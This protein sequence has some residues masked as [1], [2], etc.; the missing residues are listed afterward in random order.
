MKLKKMIKRFI[1]VLLAMIMGLML[2]ACGGKEAEQTGAPASEEED[3]AA[4]EEETK[5]EEAKEEE[6]KEES[7]N[8]ISDAPSCIGYWKYDGQEVYMVVTNDLNWITY[9]KDGNQSL[10]GEVE[11]D[12]DSFILKGDDISINLR[13]TDEGKLVDEDGTSFTRMDGFEFATSGDDELTQTANF[14]WKFEAYS[15]NY[16]DRMN[17]KPRT[18]IANSLDFGYKST[19]K[20]SDDYFSTIMVTFQPLVD[21][22]KYMGKGAGLAKPCMGYLLN[23]AMDALYGKYIKKSLGTDFRDRGS[24]YEIT[25]YMWLDGNI[26]PEAPDKEMMGVMQMRYFGPT[27]YAL[28]AVTVAPTETIENYFKVCLRMLN[29]CTYKT[30]WSTTPKPVPKKAGK[31]KS[32][33]V[34]PSG[35]SGDYGTPYYWTDSDGD[36]WYWNGRENIFQSYGDDGYIDDDGQFYESNDAGWDVD[37][38]VEDYSDWSDPGDY[39]DWSDPGDYA[40]YSDPGD[41]GDYGDYGDDW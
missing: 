41:Y 34:K 7:S 5:E 33:K 38:Y 26:Y 37:N 18:D 13:M 28:I 19:M 30:N 10:R 40:D 22:D 31:A 29:T 9:D 8:E 20:G 39:A 24:Y 12:G 14:P 3:G 1:A 11:V 16:P 27:G 17:A 25:G 23:N 36:I 35:D 15:I 2:A 4:A 21:V 32:N 6:T